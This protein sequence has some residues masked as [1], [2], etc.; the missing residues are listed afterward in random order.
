MCIAINK[1]VPLC[2]QLVDDDHLIMAGSHRTRGTAAGI[3]CA[4]GISSLL[5]WVKGSGV[6]GRLVG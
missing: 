4:R 5:T 2:N 1:A 6:V 3:S